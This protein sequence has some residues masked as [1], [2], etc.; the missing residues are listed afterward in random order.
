[1]HN[2]PVVDAPQVALPLAK[3]NAKVWMG[4]EASAILAAGNGGA[5]RCGP[6]PFGPTFEQGG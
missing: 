2:A 4:K 5:Q 6:L 3:G 1:M